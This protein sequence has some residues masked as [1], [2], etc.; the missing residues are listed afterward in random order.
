MAVLVDEEKRPGDYSIL[1]DVTGMAGGTYL[2]QMKGGSSVYTRK[3]IVVRVCALP[4]PVE[5][6]SR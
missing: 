6:R 5:Y 3:L 1:L 4:G 2:Y